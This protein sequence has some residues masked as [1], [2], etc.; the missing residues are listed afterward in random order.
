MTSVA[1]QTVARAPAASAVLPLARIEAKRY[2]RHPL[3]LTGLALGTLASA[4]EHGPVE[5][6]Y[7][8]IPSFFIGVLGIVVAARLTTSAH[9]SQ[10]VIDSA[11]MSDTTRTLALC[12]ACAVPATAG[13]ALTLMHRMFVL[14]DPFPAWMY[15]TYGPTEQLV[16]TVV[17]PVIA[18]AGGPLLGVAV[19]RWLRFPGAALLTV[20]AVLFWSNVAAYVPAQ[21]MNARS[22]AARVLHMTT[23]YTAFASA[24]GDGNTP[25][26]VMRSY[27]GSP[28][29][30][31]VWTLA[32]CGL[33]VAAALWR[34]ADT[35]A[36]R[37][38]ARAF[39]GLTAAALVALALAVATG[40]QS[41]VDTSS[42]GNVAVALAAP[43][44][45]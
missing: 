39:L 30:F 43:T 28:V 44:R 6:D 17:V 31:A 22:L 37:V 18:C 14:A 23:P 35:A 3:F 27:T 25:T 26:S 12:L 16:I 45:G 11:P 8:V 1:V 24:N 19:G 21:S 15:G 2:A 29:W 10:P 5:L 9:R 36:R 40:N 32:L 41:L 20:V 38:L 7:H 33:A 42:S 34:G 4:G 13:L